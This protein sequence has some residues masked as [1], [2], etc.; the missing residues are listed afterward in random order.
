M[1][2]TETFDRVTGGRRLTASMYEWIDDLV[3]RFGDAAVAGAMEA[4]VGAGP[5]DK[6]MYRVRDR[7]AKKQNGERRMPIELTGKQMLAIARGEME[8]PER[9]YIWDTRDLTLAEYHELLAL[10]SGHT[11]PAFEPEPAEP[12][13]FG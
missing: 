12:G 6:L 11:S 5:M 2:A 10:R 13:M 7:L 9:P 8:E 4:E 1:K 3:G